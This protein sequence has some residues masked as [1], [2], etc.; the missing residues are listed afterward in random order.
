MPRFFVLPFKPGPAIDRIGAYSR[1]RLEPLRYIALACWGGDMRRRDF[2]RLLF[3]AALLAMPST[4]FAD[5]IP[6]L[7]FN[8]DFLKTYNWVE[9]E[10]IDRVLHDWQ[11]FTGDQSGGRGF[12]DKII[13]KTKSVEIAGLKFNGSMRRYNKSGKH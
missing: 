13:L 3:F 9:S 10:P 12:R 4:C 6:K 8:L 5:D 11:H 2:R 1:V 7:L